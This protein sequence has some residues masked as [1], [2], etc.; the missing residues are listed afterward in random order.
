MLLFS[1][2][3]KTEIS[4]LIWVM[5]KAADGFRSQRGFI[6]SKDPNGLHIEP[7]KELI[8]QL[9]KPREK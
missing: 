8:E 1:T 5:P 3:D 7:A 2:D 6:G 9:A 4:Q